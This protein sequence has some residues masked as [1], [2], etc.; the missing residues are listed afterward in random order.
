MV[1]ILSSSEKPKTSWISILALFGSKLEF[2]TDRRATYIIL[3]GMEP[4]LPRATNM[5]FIVPSEGLKESSLRGSKSI[6]PP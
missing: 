5:T 4:V 3:E 6:W 1:P 2:S